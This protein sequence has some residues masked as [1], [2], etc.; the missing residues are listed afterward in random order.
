MVF[1]TAWVP[2]LAVAAA[3][4][5]F[6]YL[7]KRRFRA[8]A[9]A[10]FLV[11]GSHLLLDFFA[12]DFVAPYGLPLLW[13]LANRYFI[14]AQPVFINISRSGRSDDFFISLFNHHNL[15]A[16]G[17]EIMILGGSA[18]RSRSDPPFAEKKAIAAIKKTASAAGK[19]NLGRIAL[20]NDIVGDLAAHHRIGRDDDP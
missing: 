16:A 11:F 6:F 9:A 2:P 18:G 20:D 19:N 13:P 12:W 5:C 1:F 17:R 8:R 3:G 15:T 4:G 7:T 14:A 10:I